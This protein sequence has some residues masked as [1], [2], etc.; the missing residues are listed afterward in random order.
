MGS[1]TT[2][3]LL[4]RHGENDWVGENR[5]AGRTPNVHLNESGRK[6]SGRI[7]EALTDH[8]L[9][10]VYSSPMERCVETAQPV[11]ERHGLAVTPE[12]GVLEVDYGEWQ[13]GSIKELSKSP[14]WQLVQHAPS[15]FRFPGGE[16][17]YEVQTRAVATVERIREHHPDQLVAIF[18][19]GDVIRTTIA[20][21]MGIPID[22]FQ[23]VIISTGA[24]SAIAFHGSMARVLFTNYQT[25]LPKFEFKHDEDLDGEHEEEQSDGH[26]KVGEN[27]DRE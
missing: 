24:I 21:Y 2:F 14:E 26:D 22:L 17:L 23:R 9:S 13:G 7:V 5:L 18:S 3:V 1:P 15:S 16:T 10:A 8:P 12:T 6:Q 11:A 19:H 20:H 4:I 27:T 25:Q